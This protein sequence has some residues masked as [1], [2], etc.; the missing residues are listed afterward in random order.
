MVRVRR[1]LFK[2][3]NGSGSGEEY[4]VKV[5]DGVWQLHVAGGYTYRVPSARELENERNRQQHRK[6]YAC[7]KFV[8]RE[9]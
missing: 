5:M 7:H 8:E 2:K 9:P 4:G 1:N 3:P 6:R